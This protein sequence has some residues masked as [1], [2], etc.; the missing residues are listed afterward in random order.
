MAESVETGRRILE[1]RA[2]H[3]ALTGLGNRT[4][5]EQRYRMAL[6]TGTAHRV[7]IL[8]VDLDGFELI[9]DSSGHLVGDKALRHVA[10]R[11]EE[12]IRAMP[13]SVES[14]ETSSPSSSTGVTPPIPRRARRRSQRGS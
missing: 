9:N 14:G 4:L 1:Q 2:L 6:E 8:F 12:S 10:Q 3:D 5:L 11:L 7:S 13:S